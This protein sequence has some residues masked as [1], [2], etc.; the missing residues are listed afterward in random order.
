M[1]PAQTARLALI[2]SFCCIMGNGDFSQGPITP[3]VASTMLFCAK[4]ASSS[5]KPP[6]RMNLCVRSAKRSQMASSPG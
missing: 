5:E 6:I 2:S 1:P 3:R 4:E